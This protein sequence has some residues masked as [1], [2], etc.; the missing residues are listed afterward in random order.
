LSPKAKR[1][2]SPSSAEPFSLSRTKLDDFLNCPRCFYLDRR[3]G[4]SK[5][6][7]PAFTLNSAV[8]A[9]LKREFDA[10]RA[11]Q[12]PHPIM[13]RYGIVAVP[14]QHPGLDIW[15]NNFKGIR[16]FHIPSSLILFGSI[17][18]IWVVPSGEL[19]VVDY[20]ATSSKEE[21]ITLNT[22]YRQGYKRQIETYQWLFRRNGFKVSRRS[23]ILYANAK[24]D[25]TGLDGR[26]DFDLQL[27]E[28]IGNDD[29]IESAL[30]RA[31]KCLMND[32][33]PDSGEGCEWCQYRQANPER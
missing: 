24:K 11:K 27:I 18:D 2:F 19:L 33:P 1:L 6:S 15:R 16:F 8:D 25:R 32:V 30:L 20:K 21:V 17:D 23:F 22:E 31:K 12:E 7:L 14:F 26:L 28:H 29:W 5:P 3:L 13:M 9:L 4:I 10:Y